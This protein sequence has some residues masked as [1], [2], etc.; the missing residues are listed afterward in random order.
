[1]S[2]R[3]PKQHAEPQTC[4]VCGAGVLAAFV[5]PHCMDRYHGHLAY[6]PYVMMDLRI[7]HARLAKKGTGVAGR[8]SAEQPL[9]YV[10]AASDVAVDLTGV[11]A[12]AGDHDD[13]AHWGH[14][15]LHNRCHTIW[16]GT[17]E[18]QRNII[19]ERLLGLPKS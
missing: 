9:P 2:R 17:S 10:Q 3:R 16:G 18:V 19:A 4:G 5:C 15:L 6:V 12:I 1:M 14:E 11:A 13:D 7:E 8:G